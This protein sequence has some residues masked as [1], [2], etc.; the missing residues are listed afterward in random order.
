MNN[1]RFFANFG[2]TAI[3]RT[4][5]T[6]IAENKETIIQIQ[7]ITQ[8]PFIRFIQNMKSITAETKDVTCESHMADQDLSNQM[9]I[10]FNTSVFA[11][12][13]SLDLSNIRMFASM[14]SPMESISPAIDDRVSTIQLIFTIAST[15]IM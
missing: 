5:D 8:N 14:A 11:L 1:L 9:F 3:T 2:A 6:H 7:S 4:L 12:I 10:D 13:S 15:S